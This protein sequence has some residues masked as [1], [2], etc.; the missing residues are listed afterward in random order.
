MCMPRAKHPES[1]QLFEA[2]ERQGWQAPEDWKLLFADVV[3]R[4]YDRSTGNFKAV[5]WIVR[6]AYYDFGDRVAGT[7]IVQE[8]V[9]LPVL[10]VNIPTYEQA[11][12]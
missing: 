1:Y 6:V 4:I 12:L 10:D 8:R 7:P 11:S 5:G 9:E 3:S 2:L